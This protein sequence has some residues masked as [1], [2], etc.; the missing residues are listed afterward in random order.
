LAIAQAACTP[1]DDDD[2]ASIQPGGLAERCLGYLDKWHDRFYLYGEKP[3][4]QM[5]ILD[6]LIKH[7][8]PK[9]D[10]TPKS[11]PV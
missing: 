10:P 1:E 7:E 8:E 11:A 2:W 9:S 6:R 5:P 4:L 3:F